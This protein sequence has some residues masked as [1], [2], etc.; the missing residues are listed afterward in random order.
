MTMATKST[1]T[2]QRKA[3]RVLSP[4][5]AKV[6]KIAAAV[7]EGLK[8]ANGEDARILAVADVAVAALDDLQ[9]GDTLDALKARQAEVR[10]MVAV[11]ESLV[12]ALLTVKNP[13][14]GR[15]MTNA[16]VAARL[17]VNATRITQIKN[18]A[19]LVAAAEGSGVEG[20][21]VADA[22]KIARGGD[23]VPSIA[24]A[25]GILKSGKVPG[26]VGKPADDDTVSAAQTIAANLRRAVN[27]TRSVSVTAEDAEALAQIVADAERLAQ[28]ATGLLAAQ[29][30]VKRSA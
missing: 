27:G 14:T 6:Q 11:R 10:R 9:R 30:K 5:E 16:Q 15:K 7:R 12:P 20:F 13:E 17:G 21:T 29:S 2:A 23:G 28:W 18:T 3:E 22:R 26:I 25:E 8:D 1:K 19:R 4:V 24:E